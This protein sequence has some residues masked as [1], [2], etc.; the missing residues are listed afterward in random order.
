LCL[1]AGLLSLPFSLFPSAELAY[2]LP[3]QRE[4][5]EHI[6]SSAEG[7]REKGRER[8]YLM[9]FVATK[10][11]ITMFCFAFRHIVSSYFSLDHPAFVCF[12]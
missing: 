10:L 8:S 11:C 5:S 3:S 7:K 1:P 6:G 2:V 12:T 4:P 9:A